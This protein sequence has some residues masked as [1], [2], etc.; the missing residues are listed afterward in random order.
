MFSR[1]YAELFSTFNTYKIK[2]LVVGAHAVI[3]YSQPRFTKDMDVWV[4]AELNDPQRVYEAL[5]AYGAPLRRMTPKNFQDPTMI[6]Q[7]GVP[8]VRVDILVSLPG[9][10]AAEAWK[11]RRRSR[12]GRVPINIIGFDNLIQ[13]KKAI[14]RLQDR[15]DLEKLLPGARNK[16]R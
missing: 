2:Y 16:K 3:F 13:A 15:L 4:P 8:P 5:K 1:D 7:I 14:G 9:V 12:Y 11:R 6:F 10:S